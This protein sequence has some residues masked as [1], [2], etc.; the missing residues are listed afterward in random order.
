MGPFV[1]GPLETGSF[2]SFCNTTYFNRYG[3][4]F[5]VLRLNP[6]KNGVWDPVPELTIT[7]PYVHSR[8]DSITYTMSNAITEPTLTLC[9]SRLYPPSQGLRIWPL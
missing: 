2:V 8:V 9:Q 7:S 4:C 5:D 3:H 6:K 1:L